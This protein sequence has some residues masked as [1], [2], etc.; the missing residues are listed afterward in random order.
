ML[1]GP[2]KHREAHASQSAE[3]GL[4]EAPALPAFPLA[5]RAPARRGALAES[6]VGHLPGRAWTKE[7]RGFG[8]HKKKNTKLSVKSRS[9]F[10]IVYILNFPT[11][12]LASGRA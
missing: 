1:S 3:D 6:C 7:L 5:L 4:G 12:H 10:S 9:C 8:A 11:P 2:E